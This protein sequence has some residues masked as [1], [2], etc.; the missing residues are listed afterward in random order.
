MY[1]EPFKKLNN[2]YITTTN[3]VNFKQIAPISIKEVDNNNTSRQVM[4]ILTITLFSD[5]CLLLTQKR[6]ITSN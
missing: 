4:L 2:N 1:K 5:Q 6:R 3:Q